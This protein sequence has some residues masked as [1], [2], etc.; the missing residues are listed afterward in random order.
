MPFT[1]LDPIS[2]RSGASKLAMRSRI[3]EIKYPMMEVEGVHECENYFERNL[4]VDSILC[5][6]SLAMKVK[7]I[8]R[9]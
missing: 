6:V 9:C 5:E 8:L 4:F 7:E 3:M 1:M 2:P